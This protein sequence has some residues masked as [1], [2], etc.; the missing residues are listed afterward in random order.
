MSGKGHGGGTEEA[1]RLDRPEGLARALGSGTL[2]TGA[3][4]GREGGG[5]ER[6]GLQGEKETGLWPEE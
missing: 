1:T 3:V 5:V 6:E 2:Q 4:D